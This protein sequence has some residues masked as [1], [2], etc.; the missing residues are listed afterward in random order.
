M[1]LTQL[2]WNS[3]TYL[4]LVSKKNLKNFCKGSVWNSPLIHKCLNE[5]I[6]ILCYVH[7]VYKHG[8]WTPREEIVFTAR[9]KIQSQSQI[10]RYGGSI[11]CL[12]HRPNFSDIFDSCL[13]WVSV[14][15]GP[16]YCLQLYGK[17]M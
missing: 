5:F 13:H 10:F 17:P 11:F 7:F 6:I 12:P 8:Q 15:R 4:S 16:V 2:F 3:N 14:V 9:Q 1:F